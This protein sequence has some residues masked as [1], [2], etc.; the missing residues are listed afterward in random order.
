VE[1]EYTNK[2]KQ[3]T[4]RRLKRKYPNEAIGVGK[5]T[6]GEKFMSY[7][8]EKGYKVYHPVEAFLL[9]DDELKLF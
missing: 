4:L 8:E 3:E 9:L 6:F 7:L 5:S 2:I 1:S